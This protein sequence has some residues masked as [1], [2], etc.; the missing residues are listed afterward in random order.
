MASTTSNMT[1]RKPAPT[2]TVDVTADLSDNFQKIDDLTLMNR[3]SSIQ[4]TADIYWSSGTLVMGCNVKADRLTIARSIMPVGTV[5]EKWYRMY[6][7]DLESLRANY[8]IEFDNIR[9][10]NITN[11]GIYL[12]FMATASELRGYNSAPN[13]LPV[14]I[15]RSGS[16]IEIWVQAKGHA[17][18]GTTIWMGN[19]LSQYGP[20]ITPY[21]TTDVAVFGDDVGPVVDGPTY[22]DA[23][24]T[25]STVVDLTQ[26]GRGPWYP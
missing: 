9:S 3:G 12:G 24:A 16:R 15:A 18:E 20:S 26:R 4:Q 7:L 10:A 8:R 23:G 5:S 14:K 25:Y 2:D 19:V 22:D 11:H 13:I 17:G 1:L 21:E 6:V